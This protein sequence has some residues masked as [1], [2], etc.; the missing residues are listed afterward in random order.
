MRVLDV[1]KLG[2]VALAAAL[3]I[4]VPLLAAEIRG[5]IKSID[6]NLSQIVVHDEETKSDV[7]VSLAALA[8]KSTGLG[9]KVDVK[10]L[11]PGSRVV[12]STGV[13]ASKVALDESRP[14]EASAQKSILEEFCHN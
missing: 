7:V 5:E 2:L 1:P 3:V 10:D 6:R 14:A 8:A 12:V 9:K 13:V 4:A 11:K